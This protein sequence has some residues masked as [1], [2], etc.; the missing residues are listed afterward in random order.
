MTEQQ[1]FQYLPL[2]LLRESKTNPRRQENA[3]ALKELIESVRD[4]GVLVPL[5]VR[6]TRGRSA[7][8]HEPVDG[9]YEI[10]AGSRRYRAA[11]EAGLLKVPVRVRDMT[12]PEVLEIQIIENLQRE[13]VH[14]LDEGLGYRVLMEKSKLDVPAIAKKVGKSASYVYQRMKLADLDKSVQK[15]T[16][17]KRISAGHAILI[18]RLQ[19]KEQGEALKYCRPRYHGGGRRA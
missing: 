2:A 4:R 6:P 11:K 17:E 9:N 1:E 15:A 18:A 7:I 10:V 16:L 19:P 8:A 3:P 14:P 13:D 12:D 5:L